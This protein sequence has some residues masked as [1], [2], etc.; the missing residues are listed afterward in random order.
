MIVLAST[1]R[2][3]KALLER[4]G[5][6][7]DV[8]FPDC[9]ERKLEAIGGH[10]G[11]IALR[12]AHAKAASVRA[13]RRGDLVIGSDQFVVCDGE[14][15]HK[16]VTPERA[17]QQLQHLSGRTHELVTGVVILGP[18]GFDSAHVDVHRLRMRALEPDAIARYVECDQ[19][20]D[21][22]GS[23]RV[24]RLGISLFESVEGEDFTAIEGL[25][26][27][28]VARMLRKAGLQIP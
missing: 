27:I 24:E 1:S 12:L 5:I 21:C 17:C 16:P 28:A 13:R 15:L 18:S 4:L 14:I 8:E 10:S 6:S 19:P 22:C 3:R 20:L 25:P 11:E 7:F 2:Y 9:D 23:Y 26:L